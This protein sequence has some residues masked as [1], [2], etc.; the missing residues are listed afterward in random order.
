MRISFQRSSHNRWHQ[1]LQLSFSLFCRPTCL[2]S[3]LWSKR[4]VAA[5]YFT[6]ALMRSLVFVRALRPDILQWCFVSSLKMQFSY[7]GYLENR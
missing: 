4:E 6:L 7:P 3:V 2:L 1:M 5:L